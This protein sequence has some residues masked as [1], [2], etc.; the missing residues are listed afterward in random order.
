MPNRAKKACNVGF[1][2][3]FTRKNRIVR[4]VLKPMGAKGIFSPKQLLGSSVIIKKK[5]GEPKVRNYGI[6]FM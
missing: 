2:I 4:K 6:I 5:L 3:F 1:M